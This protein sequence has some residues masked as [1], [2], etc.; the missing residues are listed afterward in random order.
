MVDFSRDF[1]HQTLHLSQHVL[2]KRLIPA[3]SFTGSF[4]VMSLRILQCSLEPSGSRLL[5]RQTRRMTI[6]RRLQFRTF[7]CSTKRPLLPVGGNATWRAFH[8]PR[9]RRPIRFL[10][11]ASAARRFD[12]SSSAGVSAY[13]IATISVW[14]DAS[15]DP[16]DCSICCSNTLHR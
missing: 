13:E 14:N 12:V 16:T 10:L 6:Q 11:E 9:G 2:Q 1:R 4:I 15:R 5:Q 7:L 3:G 8:R